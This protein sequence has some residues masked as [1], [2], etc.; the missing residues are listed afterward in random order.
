LLGHTWQVC[1][2]L[3]STGHNGET[4]QDDTLNKAF[5]ACTNFR[6]KDISNL[7]QIFRD[8]LH[9]LY[10]KLDDLNAEH[11]NQPEDFYTTLSDATKAVRDS[12]SADLDA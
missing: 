4:T 9:E 12:Y 1:P 6:G 5:V 3:I 11:V 8:N 7:L 10:D 2:T